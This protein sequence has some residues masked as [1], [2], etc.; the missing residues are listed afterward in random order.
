MSAA[1][2]IGDQRL[3]IVYRYWLGKRA[4][5]AMP[6]PDSIAL[7]ELPSSVRPNAMILDIVRADGATRFRYRHVGE[8]FWRAT[9][10]DP[11][12]TF[13][14]EALPETVGYRDYV[15]GIYR[16]MA[17]TARPMYTENAFILRHG[18]ADPMKT[19]RVSLPLSRDGITADMVLA[20][21]VFDYGTMGAEAFALVTGLE[22]RVRQFLAT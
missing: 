14:D 2:P 12:G 9:G 11:V 4:A 16:E 21:H 7:T 1:D 5:A 10:R 19:K 6:A 8:V 20:A 13:V 15:V 17:E 22:E 18:Q 3:A